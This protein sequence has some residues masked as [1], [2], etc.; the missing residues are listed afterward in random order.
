[1]EGVKLVILMTRKEMTSQQKSQRR[2]T[3]KKR[4]KIR[5]V[6]CMNPHKWF[7]TFVTKPCQ[8][9]IPTT[10]VLNEEEELD[11]G[12]INQSGIITTTQGSAE[13]LLF[14]NDI[15][16]GLTYEQWDIERNT[17]SMLPKYAQMSQ[18]WMG[19]MMI[20]WLKYSSITSR[21]MYFC[22]CKCVCVVE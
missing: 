12:S 10:P 4:R 8:E 1:V 9:T 2:K 13:Q 11:A 19:S 20:E 15:I 14:G 16:E 5:Y 3:L 7:V 18:M 22:A 21:C 17:V 6:R